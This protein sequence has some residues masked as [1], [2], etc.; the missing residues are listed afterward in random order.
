MPPVFEEFT[1]AIL[2]KTLIYNMHNGGGCYHTELTKENTIQELIGSYGDYLSDPLRYKIIDK[3]L[4]DPNT[5]SFEAFYDLVESRSLQ[6]Q[7]ADWVD[8]CPLSNDILLRW[9]CFQIGEYQYRI[10]PQ[11]NP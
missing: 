8:A 4:L 6:Y 2:D 9:N 5:T 1:N 10:K 3:N 7:A 11:W